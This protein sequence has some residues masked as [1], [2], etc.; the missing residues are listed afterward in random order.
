MAAAQ[1][2]I[3]TLEANYKAELNTIRRTSALKVELTGKAHDPEDIIKL[4][5]LGKIELDDARQPQNLH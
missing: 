1:Q 2:K 3:S 4:L 5:D